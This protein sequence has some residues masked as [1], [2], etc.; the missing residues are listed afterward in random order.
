MR[1]N[2]FTVSAESVQ[3]NAKAEVT[4]RCLKVGELR[5]WRDDPAQND[6]TLLRSHLIDW[7]GMVDDAGEPLPVQ[8]L[9]ELYL[10]EQR[11]LTRLLLQGPDGPQAKN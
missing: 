9:D 1:R 3:G 2:Q 4:F 7:T 5:E 8:A 10:H 11:A 6:T